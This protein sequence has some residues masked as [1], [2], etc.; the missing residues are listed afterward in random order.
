MFEKF[1]QERSAIQKKFMLPGLGLVIV[2]V[3]L[4]VVSLPEVAIPVGIIGFIVAAIGFSKSS[5]L[6]KAL[7]EKFLFELLQPSLR[8]L[9]D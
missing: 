5:R 2:A 7:K 6:A 3:I 1:N 9:L 8:E 4:F